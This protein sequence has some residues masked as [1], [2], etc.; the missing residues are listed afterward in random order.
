MSSEPS[1]AGAAAL[2][3]ASNSA[4]ILLKAIAGAITGSVALLADLIHNVGDALTAVPLGIAFW[5][6]S[7]SAERIVSG[8]AGLRLRMTSQERTAWPNPWEVMV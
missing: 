5:L 8:S 6:R 4:L 2:S 1:K 3:V 7:G